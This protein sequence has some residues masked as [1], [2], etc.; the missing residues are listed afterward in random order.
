MSILGEFGIYTI[1]ILIERVIKMGRKIVTGKDGRRTVIETGKGSKGIV[2]N[3]GSEE[4]KKGLVQ[5]IHNVTPKDTVS[6]ATQIA[7]SKATLVNT[8]EHYKQAMEKAGM[9][10]PADLNLEET[11]RRSYP[12]G[13]S[14]RTNGF[15]I[16]PGELGFQPALRV[17]KFKTPMFK[18]TGASIE[19]LSLN[20]VAANSD[21]IAYQEDYVRRVLSAASEE[22]ILNVLRKQKVILTREAVQ[23]ANTRNVE[24]VEEALRLEKQHY[25]ELLEEGKRQDAA[26]VTPGRKIEIFLADLLAERDARKA[27]GLAEPRSPK[28]SEGIFKQSFKRLVNSH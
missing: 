9:P 10:E 19:Q 25:A 1:I 12:G 27:T 16:N 4:A 3:L 2:D 15:S 13:I 7:A 20:L 22:E 6:L 11:K 21:G 8:Y 28:A 18:I 17:D 26:N 23:K 24:E 5:Q 14:G